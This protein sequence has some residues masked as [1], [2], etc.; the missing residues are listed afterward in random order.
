M[1]PYLRWLMECCL[2]NFGFSLDTSWKRTLMS[3]VCGFGVYG[4]ERVELVFAFGVA[5]KSGHGLPSVELSH[6]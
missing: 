3:E 4:A 2:G 6:S 1:L 5:G